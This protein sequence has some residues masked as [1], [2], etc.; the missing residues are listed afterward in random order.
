MTSYFSQLTTE[1]NN[2][3]TAS[4]DEASTR[5]MLLLMNDEDQR[6]PLSVRQEVDT[7]A[8]AVDMIVK[9]LKSGGRMFYVGA[10]SSG[11]LG[12]LDASECPPTY[13]TDPAM[14]QAYIAG[15]DIALRTAVEGCE[16]DAES[17]AQLIVDKG[18]GA[19]DVLIGITASGSTPYVLGAVRKA[20]EAGA[21]TI[22]IVTNDNSRLSELCDICIAP[23]VGPEVISGSTRL[24]SGT[25]QKLVLNMLTTGTMIKLGKVYNNLMVDLKASNSKL[26]DRSIRIVRQVT[27]VSEAEA[28]ETLKK[29]DLHVKTAI[30]MLEAGVDAEEATSLLERHDGRL[31][32]AI[33]GGRSRTT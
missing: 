16:D 28:E 2:P 12:V 24:K 1:M 11:R 10:G 25:A 19:G 18:I 26:Y 6:V 30:L 32:A 21:A 7:I 4:I 8:D 23:V 13:G 29:A 14:V 15:G 33:R 27:G 20:R 17:G 3:A 9:S 5:D 22:G 31:K